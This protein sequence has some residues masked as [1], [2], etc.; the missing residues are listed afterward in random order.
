MNNE[1]TIENYEQLREE[2][3]DANAN[4]TGVILREKEKLADEKLRLL[5]DSFRKSV[6]DR[7]IYD[8]PVLSDRE[9]AE[10]PLYRF[11]HRLP[12]GAELHVHDMTLLPVSELVP[13][14][15]DCP[16]FCI[17][18][19]RSSCDLVLAPPSEPV[20]EGYMRFSEAIRTGYYTCGDLLHG[21]TTL[22]AADSGCKAWPFLER[23]FDRQA[24]LSGNPAFA[25]KYYDRAF[26][27]Y[28]RN[29][30]M[31]IEIH[32]ML[33]DSIDDSADYARAVRQ[34]YYDVKK[35][36]PYFTVRL[37]GAGVKADSENIEFTKMCF[38]NASYVQ[39]TVRDESDPNHVRDFLI[40]F[41]LVNEED[42]S[43]PLR[44]FVP[45]LLKVKKRYPSMKLY[46]HGGES[47]DASND[48]L[49]DAYLLGVSR[50]GHGLNLY[51]FP[52]LHARY[53]RS[54]ICL[55]LCP[56][57]NQR[58]GYTVDVRSHPA[59]EY[60]R[61]GIAVS[62]C[63]DDPAYMENESLTDDF[64]AAVVCWDLELADLKQLGINSI[65][66]SG[67]EQEDKIA[68]LKTYNRLWNDFID[69]FTKS[70][71]DGPASADQ[72]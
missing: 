33:T 37:I 22:G 31:H 30:I 14:L 64:F 72:E 21:W 62:L 23:L 18:T 40:G 1:C 12:K 45:M 54:E 5:K 16:E 71:P 59:T 26:R 11:C 46:I 4:L 52:D 57:S 7:F 34:A 9:L 42:T 58:L 55:E 53:V 29:N 51:R 39:E 32:I 36:Y 25:A 68:A 41:D 19:D 56:V 28:C 61:S 69:E 66:Y 65:L 6:G 49:I 38:L 63:S 10:S 50:V 15:A 48:N 13:L 3:K 47:L 43:L 27:Y 2:I 70:S 24:V 35:D 44:A 67:L 60:L 17:S 20:P 8:I